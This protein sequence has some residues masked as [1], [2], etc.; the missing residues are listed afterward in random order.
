MTDVMYADVLT[1]EG[2]LDV[3]LS[4][5]VGKE[6]REVCG[7]FAD[8][9]GGVSFKLTHIIFDDGS[10]VGIE[11]EHDFPYVATFRKWTFPTLEEETLNRL[12]EAQNAEEE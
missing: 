3:G 6:I 7:Y 11:G 5:L 10:Q 4:R 1:P 9:G 8:M 2:D 12:Y